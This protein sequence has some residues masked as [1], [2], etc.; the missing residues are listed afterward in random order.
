MRTRMLNQKA[1][2][3]GGLRRTLGRQAELRFRQLLSSPAATGPAMLLFALAFLFSAL[4]GGR[5]C[6][7]QLDSDLPQQWL[8]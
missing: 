5:G 6:S 1:F 3:P 8:E 4:P 2:R 7:G